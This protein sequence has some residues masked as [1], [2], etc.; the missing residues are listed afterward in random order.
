MNECGKTVNSVV[1]RCIGCIVI[2]SCLELVD[3]LFGHVLLYACSVPFYVYALLCVQSPQNTLL[4]GCSIDDYKVYLEGRQ[5]TIVS[6]YRDV[7]N[8][9]WPSTR[10]LTINP[11]LANVFPCKPGYFHAQVLYHCDRQA[12]FCAQLFTILFL[13]YEIQS[14]L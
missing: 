8:F 11:A 2:F 13:N 5:G 9:L 7:L 12:I 14:R 10:N 4:R 1:L 6:V 3:L